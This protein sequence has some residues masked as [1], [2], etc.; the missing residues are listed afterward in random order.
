MLEENNLAGVSN[1]LIACSI[2]RCA[3]W[4]DMQLVSYNCVASAAR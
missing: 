2:A 3:Q 1:T 4:L